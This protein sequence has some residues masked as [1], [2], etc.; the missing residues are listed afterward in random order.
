M[1]PQ[2]L[3]RL[4]LLAVLLALGTT[5]VAA[6]PAQAVGID[7]Q[8]TLGQ[9]SSTYSPGITNTP[10]TVTLTHSVSYT[11]CLFGGPV[12][13]A[14]YGFGPFSAPGVSCTNV[15]AQH[16][17]NSVYH[18][19]DG[20]TSTIAAAST[21]TSVSGLFTTVETTGTVSAGAFLGDTMVVQSQYLTPGGLACLGSGLTSISSLSTTLTLLSI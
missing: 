7:L 14:T 12:T 1:S 9:A 10:Q 19:N 3:I 18:W 20:T 8:C 16:P 2:R 13:G 6:S 5:A 11:G 15:L 4:G 21:S 17:G